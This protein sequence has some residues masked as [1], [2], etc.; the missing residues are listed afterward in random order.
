MKIQIS[1]AIS[2]NNELVMIFLNAMEFYK[3]LSSVSNLGER[4]QVVP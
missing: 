4:D 3:T 1:D 2:T